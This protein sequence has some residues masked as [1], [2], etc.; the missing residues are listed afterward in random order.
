MKSYIENELYTDCPENIKEIM[1][2]CVDYLAK[3][4]LTISEI[5]YLSDSLIAY[6]ER[7][8]PVTTDCVI[9]LK[10]QRL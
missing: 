5:R 9:D 1:R 10:E 2:D 6:F 4:R 8:M 7:F 3:K